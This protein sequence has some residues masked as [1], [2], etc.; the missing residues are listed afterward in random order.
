MGERTTSKLLS[1]D[2]IPAA[3]P[4]AE[5]LGADRRRTRCSA[6]VRVRSIDGVPF[7]YLTTHV[8]ERIGRTYSRRSSPATPLLEL[9]ERSGVKIERAS[10]RISAVLATPEIAPALQGRDRLAADRAHARRL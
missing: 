10:Q 7:S 1:F 2:Y 4:I 6:S 5:A 3:G 8:P 9:L